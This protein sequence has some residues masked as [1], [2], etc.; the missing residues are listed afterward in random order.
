M[1]SKKPAPTD[2]ELLAELDSLGTEDKPQAQAQTSK[3]AKASKKA[4]PMAQEGEDLLAELGSL[5]QERPKSRPH[6]PRVSGSIPRSSGD[7]V[8]SG[9]TSEEGKEKAS[10]SAPAMAAGT[11]AG[12]KS[13]ESAR[14][15][16]PSFAPSGEEANAAPLAGGGEQEWALPTQQQTQ[17]QTQA[18]GGSWWG[19]FVATATAAVTQAQAIA[20]DLQNNEEAQ[21][22][23]DQVKGNVGVLRNYGNSQPKWKAPSMG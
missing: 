10:T 7:I 16:Q 4:N 13:A 15:Y 22:W 14:A 3:A 23:A 8:A 5:A 18:S 6:T 9:R 21:K 2:E 17:Q 12:R 20:K 11:N 19:G 1:A